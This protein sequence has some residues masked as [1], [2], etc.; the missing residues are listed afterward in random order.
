[1]IPITRKVNRKYK[2]RE[3]NKQVPQIFNIFSITRAEDEEYLGGKT[4]VNIDLIQAYEE[5]HQNV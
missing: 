1:M 4:H 5:L 3:K 2:V